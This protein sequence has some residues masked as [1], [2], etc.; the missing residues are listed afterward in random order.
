MS[1]NS[2]HVVYFNLDRNARPDQEAVDEPITSQRVDLSAQTYPAPTNAGYI[3]NDP[4]V[5]IEVEAPVL[6][7]AAQIG[8]LDDV[9]KQLGPASVVPAFDPDAVLDAVL[10]WAYCKCSY[11]VHRTGLNGDA[12]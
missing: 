2:P 12:E 8:Q 11:I 4:V 9:R 10:D 1:A 7:N 6:R 5:Q 3:A